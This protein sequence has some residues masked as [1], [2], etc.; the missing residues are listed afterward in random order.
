LVGLVPASSPIGRG[1]VAL[2]ELATHRLILP[3]MSNPLRAEIEARA[4]LEG[5]ELTVPIEV[6]GI[7]L[8][9]D[10]VASVGGASI[11][12]ATAIAAELTGV[13]Q[14][15]IEGM[16]PRRL[17]LITARDSRLSL[18][19]QEVRKAVLELVQD[20]DVKSRPD[21]CLRALH[22]LVPLADRECRG[23][24]Q[25]D[26]EVGCV[27]EEADR[28]RRS[29]RNAQRMEQ[30]HERALADAEAAER[31]RQDLE[32]R[33]GRHERDDRGDRDLESEG[34][35]DAVDHDHGG[36]L[37]K[38]GGQDDHHRGPWLMPHVVDAAVDGADEPGPVVVR[39]VA[40]PEAGMRGK[41]QHDDQQRKC[42]TRGDE[43]NPRVWFLD[44]L[45]IV[46]EADEH[47]EREDDPAGQAFDDDTAE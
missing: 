23:A 24:Q 28:N 10:L 7:R 18:A 26:G 3:P 21:Q 2:A 40:P 6:E 46:D 36:D 4:A 29:G 22:D 39:L 9:A 42:G 13:R 32:H 16:P 17:A 12:P 34:L 37:V 14:V 45:V 27:P 38:R 11:L 43:G 33:D 20:R 30:Q 15:A 44:Q 25:A 8:I 1:P 41:D 19:D 47:D 5:I 31:Y 35:D